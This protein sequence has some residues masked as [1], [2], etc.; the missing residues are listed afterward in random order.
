MAESVHVAGQSSFSGRLN[1]A[2]VGVHP[3]YMPPE[4]AE[5]GYELAVAAPYV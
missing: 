5:V 4:I 2:W 3:F 1:G